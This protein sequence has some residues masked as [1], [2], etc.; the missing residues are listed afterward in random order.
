MNTREKMKKATRN[1]AEPVRSKGVRVKT[2]S[3]R[4]HIYRPTR[5]GSVPHAGARYWAGPFNGRV[6]RGFW[7]LCGFLGFLLDFGVFD[8]F[9]YFVQI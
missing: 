1:W 9:K 7:Q 3:E 2:N 4:N 8:G 6:F 5:G